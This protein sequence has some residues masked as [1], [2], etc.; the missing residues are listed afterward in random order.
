MTHRLT[1]TICLLVYFIMSVGVSSASSTNNQTDDLS[2][3]L[4]NSELPFQIKLEKAHFELPV[5][6]HSG[7]V[8]QYKGQ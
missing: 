6:I 8:G 2:P 5:G 1:T 7:M 4:P 3:V